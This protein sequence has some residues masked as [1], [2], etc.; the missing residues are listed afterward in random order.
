MDTT[1]VNT[2]MRFEIPIQPVHAEIA[3]RNGIRLDM[4]RLDKTDRIVSGNKWFKLI[5][6]MQAARAG[7][8]R[9]LLSFGGP[10]SNHLVAMAAAAQDAGFAS[11]GIVRGL[12]FA[13]NYTS[14]LHWCADMGM[15]LRFLSREAYALK[16]D[17]VFLEGLRREWD[18]PYIIPEGGANR[19]GREG[20]GLIAQYI[21]AHYTHICLAA[22]TG[23]TLTGLREK[24]P[25]AQQIIGFVPMKQGRYLETAIAGWLS[26][27]QNRSW[28]LTD[29]YHFGG[30]GKMTISLREWIQQF[31]QTH[32]IPLDRVYTAKMMYGV[33]DM[34]AQGAFP[35][36]AQILCIHTGGLQG[37]G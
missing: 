27:G 20:A 26:E 15:Q 11:V 32:G 37:N 14:S 18:D 23:T 16:D 35:D 5:R 21:P 9:T 34:I 6:N 12:H 1:D 29:A 24:L 30:F 4:L 36:G 2:E 3:V 33:T 10:W 7:G 8:H 22:G 13:D 25:V 19:Q 31:Y 28:S 17:P